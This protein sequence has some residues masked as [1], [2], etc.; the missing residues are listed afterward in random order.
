MSSQPGSLQEIVKRY[1]ELIER[2]PNNAEYWVGRGR[3]LMALKQPQKALP[4]LARAIEL[5][6]KDPAAPWWYMDRANA[7]QTLK[8]DDKALA[9]FSLVIELWPRVWGTWVWR[10]WFHF[11]QQQWDKCIADFTKALELK[12]TYDPA[13]HGRGEA[14]QRLG[15]W[16]QAVADY[17]K[18]AELNPN[19]SWT[20][21]GRADAYVALGQWDNAI[22][23]YSKLIELEP[24]QLA[25][26]VNHLT[27]N[28]RTKEADLLRRDV[29][30][31]FDMLAK[32]VLHDSDRK[33]LA[34]VYDAEA[35]L[36]QGA[37][38]GAEAAQTYRR[39]LEIIE[40]IGAKVDAEP[41]Y[42]DRLART[43]YNLGGLQQRIGQSG[44][45]E[46]NLRQ[47]IAIWTKLEGNASNEHM[48]RLQAAHVVIHYLTP[49]L[50]A[51]GRAAEAERTIG[52]AIADWE[53]LATKHP[54][55]ANY[56]RTLIE[57]YGAQSNLLV[58]A[59][60]PQEAE[61]ICTKGIK[62]WPN[63]PNLYAVRVRVHLAMQ[64]PDKAL[65]DLSKAIELARDEGDAPWWYLERA[66]VYTSLKQDDKALA[67][68]SKAIE[69]RPKQWH[70][71]Y[72][73]GAFHSGRQHWAK[74]AADYA[75]A[76]ELEPSYAPTW[77]ARGVAQ[78]RAGDWQGAVA[79]LTKSAELH[80]G[81]DAAQDWFFLAMAHEKL[82]HQAEARQ[83]YDRAV[84]WTEKHA[85][86]NEELRR[87]RAEAAKLLGVK[88]K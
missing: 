1:S 83:W 68:Y 50:L 79:T 38:K 41:V 47:A 62:T 8:Q 58:T 34:D 56:L 70:F 22:A 61:Q 33:A 63:T 77:H 55:N 80:A 6:P 2:L 72:N 43:H 52:Q 59:R 40:K 51:S 24:S 54:G 76:L 69:L 5:T 12:P 39:A 14:Y 82:N 65:L 19:Y 9:E 66:N 10:A 57:A 16:T 29:L 45:A 74:A 85:P 64:Q 7:Y 73:R 11:S 18:A 60:R 20:W 13:W 71:W 48:Y 4:D 26:A 30:A 17:T 67:D 53:K 84:Q 78:Y 28:G 15:K 21:R 87:L 42:R 27:S 23:D 25:H 31:H 36:L 88:L 44:E 46:K 75:K 81:A 32:R 3:A 86:Q 49:L 37:G 35:S